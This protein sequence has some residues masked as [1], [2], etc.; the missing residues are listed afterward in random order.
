MDKLTPPFELETNGGASPS[1]GAGGRGM[2]S[3]DVMASLLFLERRTHKRL[4]G[5]S[6]WEPK[7]LSSVGD[8]RGIRGGFVGD[9]RGI[10]VLFGGFAL[11]ARPFG[12]GFRGI[13]LRE[14]WAFIILKGVRGSVVVCKCRG[15]LPS[16]FSLSV[17]LSVQHSSVF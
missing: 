5:R 15:R 8:S 11:E 7:K 17:S 13:R 12:V 9:Y 14:L 4:E 3:E 6:L 16:S 2:L 1:P 10:R